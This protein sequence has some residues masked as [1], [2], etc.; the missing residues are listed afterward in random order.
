MWQATLAKK[1]KKTAAQH[2]PTTSSAAA[3]TSNAAQKVSPTYLTLPIAIAIPK[4][5]ANDDIQ[6]EP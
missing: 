3:N 2:T 1:Q 5:P 6:R 4:I